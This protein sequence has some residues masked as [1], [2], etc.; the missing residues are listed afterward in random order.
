MGMICSALAIDPAT[1]EHLRRD[2]ELVL[3]MT[4]LA[5]KRM[6]D[7]IIEQQI[8]RMPEAQRSAARKRREDREADMLTR[9]PPQFAAEIAKA[10]ALRERAAVL[11]FGAAMSIQ[12]SWDALHHLF[13]LDGGSLF[14]GEP[15]GP[16]QGYGPALFR[17]PDNVNAFAAFLN[18]PGTDRL[19]NPDMNWL[20]EQ[21]LYACPDTDDA[22]EYEDELR[23]GLQA[24]F[25]AL[26][27]YVQ[28]TAQRG[29]ALLIWIS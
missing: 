13:E 26:R 15:F 16:D 10:K 2:P 11:N 4:G 7:E 19:R 14:E 9:I 28:S 20:R 18:G 1:L 22:P 23:Q 17:K 3:G 6:H 27:K 29:D 25:E 12:K 24:Q 8:E 21:R 5:T